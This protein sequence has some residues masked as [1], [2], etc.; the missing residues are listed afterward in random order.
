MIPRPIIGLIGMALGVAMVEANDQVVAFMIHDFEAYWGTGADGGKWVESLFLTGLCIGMTQAPWWSETVS[1]KYWAVFAVTLACLTTIIMPFAPNIEALYALRFVQGIA[2]GFTLPLLM[3]V[4]LMVLPPPVRLYGLCIYGLTITFTA[5]FAIFWAG[6]W[7]ELVG[8]KWQMYAAL[9]L[10][11]APLA[12]I[13][14][15]MPKTPVHLSRLNKYDWSG[16]LLAIIAFG[17]FSTMLYHG[18]RLDWF[19]SKLICVLALITVIA[20]PLFV[21]NEL[22]VPAPLMGLRLLKRRDLAFALPSLF[23]F[24]IYTAAGTFVPVGVLGSVQDYKPLQAW[25]LGLVLGLGQFITLPATAWLLDHRSVDPRWVIAIGLLLSCT[26]C[27]LDS[28]MTSS[29]GWWQFMPSQVLLMIGEPM[30]ILTI[31]MI[32]TNNLTPEEGPGGSAIVNTTR[33]FGECTTSWLLG[34]VQF[35]RSSH[36][37][38]R[39]VDHQGGESYVP[40]QL[41]PYMPI[42]DAPRGAFGGFDMYMNEFGRQLSVLTTADVYRV[43][44]MLPVAIFLYMMVMA[45]RTYP[46]RILLAGKY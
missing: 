15:G 29:W 46:P 41:A 12:L 2:E 30:V 10:S 34:L 26:A 4:A 36:H 21:I 25:P 27:L 3:E 39:L 37:Y 28:Q 6:L 38:N 20:F 33:A 11:I 14:Y 42:S 9:P 24:I 16:T 45:T 32:G 43:L 7:G 1:Y 18:T 8:W 40:A 23:L 44:A 17:A 31:L 5:P 22:L 35:Y 13:I 19:E